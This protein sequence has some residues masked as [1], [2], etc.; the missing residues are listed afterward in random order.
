[1]FRSRAAATLLARQGGEMDDEDMSKSDICASC[2]QVIPPTG[3]RLPK[4]N[5]RIYDGIRRRPGITA[6]ALRDLVW[7]D[8]PNGG[9]EDRKVLH[10]HVNQLNSLLAPHGVYVR[11]EGGG[12]VFRRVTP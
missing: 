5:Q 1:M 8:D 9:P 4:I 6:A 3:L 2:G 7:A 12:Y 10:V 11:S